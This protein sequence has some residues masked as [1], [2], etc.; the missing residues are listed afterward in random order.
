MQLFEQFKT[1]ADHAA[2]GRIYKGEAAD[3]TYAQ[4]QHLQ[5]YRGQVGAHDFRVSKLWAIVKVVLFVEPVTD[6]VAYP[7]TAPCPLIGAGLGN[8][9]DGQPLHL[10]SVAV[11]RQSCPASIYHIADTGYGEGGLGHIGTEHHAPASVWREDFALLCKAQPGVKGHHF[12]MGQLGALDGQIGLANLALA[13]Q[14]DQHIAGFWFG[15]CVGVDLAQALNN[16]LVAIHFQAIDIGVDN[17]DRVGSAGYLDHWCSIEMPGE[18]FY[19]NGGR[20]N[21]QL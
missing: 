12:G 8:G 16:A 5:D 1:I 20:G 7:A 17:L 2:I 10:G 4:V 9:F 21:N 14:K 6:A 11:A 3:I 13:T 19:I 18:L 15:G